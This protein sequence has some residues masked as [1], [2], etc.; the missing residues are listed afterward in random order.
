LGGSLQIDRTTISGSTALDGAGIYSVGQLAIAD[1]RFESN[2]ATRHG[3]AIQAYRELTASSVTFV[4]NSATDAGGAVRVF[5]AY[6]AVFQDCS[7]TGNV[8]GVDGGGIYIRNG[9]SCEITGS[10]F[11]QNRAEAS[12][13]AVYLYDGSL[14]VEGSL[15]LSNSA[16]DYGG[17]IWS[18]RTSTLARC[19]FELNSTDVY[20]G[21]ALGAS[22][23]TMV[24]DSVFRSNTA[25]RNGGAIV[26]NTGGLWIGSTMFEDNTASSGDGGAIRQGQGT[27]VNSTFQG[28]CA[29]G[30]GGA[31]LMADDKY[32]SEILGCLLQNNQAG[33]DGSGTGGGIWTNQRRVA[34]TGTTIRDNATDD[35][36]GGIYVSEGLL[37]LTNSLVARNIA[38][39]GRAGGIWVANTAELAVAN[40]TISGNLSKNAG[41]GIYFNSNTN[42]AAL[43]NATITANRADRLGTANQLGGGIYTTNGNVLLQNTIVA[44]N[45]RGTGATA[46]DIQGSVD[47]VSTHNVVGDTATAGGLADGTNDNIVGQDPLLGPLRNNGGQSHTHALLSSSPAIDAGDNA[48][49]LAPDGEPLWYDQR[50]R[51]FDRV[52]GLHVD[53]GAYEYDQPGGEIHGRKWFDLDQ[54]GEEDEPWGASIVTNGG[55]E[56]GTASIGSQSTQ[57]AGS[58]AISDW[59]VLQR[60]DWVGMYW[61][62]SEGQRSIDLNATDA[63]TI[64]QVL[65]TELGRRYRVSFAMAGNPA[66]DP[67][68]KTLRLSAGDEHEEFTFDTTGRTLTEMEWETMTWEFV[69]QDSMTTLIFESLTLGTAY[70]PAIDSVVV[71]PY[72]RDD[73][74]IYLDL[75]GNATFDADEPLTFLRPDDPNTLPGDADRDGMVDGQD[76][77]ILA[78]NWGSKTATHTMGD[79]N[80]DRRVDAA[81]AAILA[82]NWGRSTPLIDETGTYRFT[83]LPPGDYTVRELLFEGFEQISPASPGSH[84]VT[85]VDDEA[86][87]DL[88]FGNLWD[89]RISG[90]KFLDLNNNGIRD[91]NLLPGDT[92]TVLMVLDVSDTCTRNAGFNVPD[93][94]SHGGAN[95]MLDA[96]I[97][98]MLQVQQ[99][100]I[101]LGWGDTA[102]VGVVAFASEAVSLDLD[103]VTAGAQWFATP[104]ADS[105]GDGITDLEA[106]LRSLRPI[107]GGTVLG[108]TDFEAA[109]QT[110]LMMFNSHSGE[111]PVMFFTSDG[112]SNNPWV[113]DDEVAQLDNLGVNRVAW[114]FGDLC[115]VS[116]LRRIDPFA[117]QLHSTLEI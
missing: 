91:R 84:E 25:A 44:G 36:G 90:T 101:T 115:D 63:G 24:V 73:V 58:T 67:G 93:Q 21:G 2:L 69:A 14:I 40:S 114:G 55:F 72:G 80:G 87:V 75:N 22:G 17:A 116:D 46:S 86:H 103:P 99:E 18:A 10:T 77:M 71:Q 53:I 66:S 13:G 61:V 34:I 54:D 106:V 113:F 102:R 28:N 104:N 3:G 35:D 96:E 31:I 5:H 110:A 8:S 57:S 51:E 42:R 88:D 65:V 16:R 108:N 64:A 12:G 9:R 97:Y 111:N 20:D 33:T 59:W 60:I 30:R 83:G 100:L 81:D 112:L 43:V 19:T 45:F 98:A 94:N 49:V 95:T 15:F 109:L 37:A 74:R 89:G 117:Q 29:G 7:F 27:I 68:V 70:G 39:N 76:A 1:S 82:A 6:A 48:L 23:K 38:T 78:V 85:I 56:Q 41:G 105:N 50:D 79:L 32:E 47:P 107:Q 26:N 11:D 52:I 4:D 92:P 62:P